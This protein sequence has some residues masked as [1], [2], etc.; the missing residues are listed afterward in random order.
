MAFDG[1]ITCGIARELEDL[2][3]LGK[4]EKVYQP[5]QEELLLHIHTKRGNVRL[6]ASAGS[7]SARLA[8]TEERYRNPT[9]PSSYCMLMRKHLQGARIT[10]LRQVGSER[11]IEM[12]LEAQTELGFTTS[13]RL[14]V[15]IMG[16]H[17]NIILV[18]LESGKIID[19]IKRISIDKNRVRQLL[20]GVIYKYPPAQD[21][22][23]FKEVTPE[24]FSANE[25]E[26]LLMNRIAGISPAI[27]RELAAAPS[28]YDRLQQ[29]L[30]SIEN[31]TA[32]A[33]I[34]LDD[35][36]P[37]EFHLTDLH[38]YEGLE[39][40][41][42]ETLSACIEFFYQHRESTNTIRQKSIPLHR[43]VTQAIEKAA[44]KKQRLAEDLLRAED[45]DR[46]RLYGELLTANIHAVRP[47]ATRV[48]VT[49][50]YTGEPIEIPLSEKLSASKNAQS[51]FKKYAKAKTAV[52][53]KAVQLE[54]TESDLTYLDSV[55]QA[56]ET[57]DT[58]EQ[59]DE[60]RDELVETG[61]L[62]YHA[63]PGVRRKKAKPQL[64]EYT[65]SDG[66]KL[67]VGRNN[68]END[69]LSM[70]LAA[71]TDL[72]FHTK[73][74]PGSHVLLKLEKGENRDNLAPQILEEAAEIAAWHSKAKNSAHVEVDCVPVRYLHKP[75]GAKPGM[76]IFTNN[77]TYTVDPKLPATEQ[78]A[79]VDHTPVQ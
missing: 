5:G 39:E 76:V 38:E 31:G 60:I 15:E 73:N 48:T 20:P 23:P 43:T 8:L 69:Y 26:R 68:K 28:P 17:S 72:W 55:L 45:S 70:R 75:N 36:K 71:K 14:V 3:L 50:Y 54:E 41:R 67:L 10:A 64:Q 12:D 79:E 34:Y 51:Y 6:L 61:Y 40:R 56:L 66:H 18:D 47:G 53:E 2:L 25:D 21:R 44:L 1:I 7:R 78:E 49:N 32:A 37:K 65:L 35:G 27:A 19:A 24:D 52:K 22:V 13:K 59:L 63:K 77:E 30:A 58:E 11:I 42:F 57:A 16:K 46:Y 74:I 4:I 62:R 29:I 9:Q 33:R